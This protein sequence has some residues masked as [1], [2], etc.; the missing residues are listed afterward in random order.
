LSTRKSSLLTGRS[1]SFDWL[2]SSNLSD[3]PLAAA[4]DSIGT[5]GKGRVRTS[6]VMILVAIGLPVLIFY[7]VFFS[8]PA[9]APED[10]EAT[11]EI[12]QELLEIVGSDYRV[13]QAYAGAELVTVNIV[14]DPEPANEEEGHMKILNALYDIQSRL[15]RERSIRIFAGQKGD[16][17]RF[18]PRS[19]LFFSTVSQRSEFK[20]LGAQ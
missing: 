17:E 20:T 3:P 11:A 9:S 8:G 16:S 7:S 1:S 2:S 5:H 6:L 14:F 4:H 19:M 10:R 13:H 18:H 15:G 12:Q